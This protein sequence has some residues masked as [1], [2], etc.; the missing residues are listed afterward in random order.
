MTPVSIVQLRAAASSSDSPSARQAAGQRPGV[1]ERLGAAA[2]E[3]HLQPPGLHGEDDDEDGDRRPGSPAGCGSVDRERVVMA[4]LGRRPR[5]PPARP[6]ATRG[7]RL[8]DADVDEVADRGAARPAWKW[9]SLFARLR[10]VNVPSFSPSTSTSCVVPSERRVDLAWRCAPAA[11]RRR[12]GGASSPPAA[13]RPPCGARRSCRAAASRRRRAP[14]RS[15]RSASTSSVCWNCASV[16]PQKPT[17]TSVLSEAPGTMLADRSHALQV[18]L[19]RVAAAHAGQH[20]VVAGLDRDVEVLADLRQLADGADDA[21][22]H[23]A[24]VGGEE[25]DARERRRSRSDDANRSARSGLRPRPRSRQVLAVGLH[26]LAQERDLA[27]AARGQR[28]APRGRCRRPGG[29]SRGRGGRGRCSRC[30]TC[31]S[32]GRR[33]RT[34]SGPF[35]SGKVSGQNSPPRSSSGIRWRMITS[36]FCGPRPDVDERE[37]LAQ[38]VGARADHAAHHGDLHAVAL[39]PS[40]CAGGDM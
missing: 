37:A 13:R 2:D 39:P 21:L 14:C 40:A 36:K 35:G 18:L 17:M 7:G 6:A 20:L 28:D 34:P 15:A 22:R 38:V 31:C 16:S 30:R 11:P 10:P 25:A 8:V 9:T 23:V 19:D 24:R 4:T 5:L 32:R 29:T 27:H 12:A 3:Q 1:L 26:R 33:A